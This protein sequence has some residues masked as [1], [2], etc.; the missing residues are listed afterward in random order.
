MSKSIN[1][2]IKRKVSE[3]QIITLLNRYI[4][5]GV[6]SLEHPQDSAAFFLQYFDN[7]SEFHQ[8]LGLSWASDD[9]ILDEVKLAMNLANELSTDVLL[10]PERLALP[11]GYQW[12]L[13]TMNNQLYAVETIDVEDGIALRPHTPKVLLTT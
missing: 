6:E 4:P 8:N 9:L 5:E 2:F 7:E 12:C 10:E 1:L 13:A 11:D 3:A